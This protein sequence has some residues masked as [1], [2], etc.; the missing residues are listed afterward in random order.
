MM[1]N[2]ILRKQSWV[3]SISKR[4]LTITPLVFSI[5]TIRILLASM[6]IILVF[7][8]RIAYEESKDIHGES[9]IWEKDS[10]LILPNDIERFRM[11]PR[12]LVDY[13][14]RRA[15]NLLHFAWPNANPDVR[16]L[17]VEN[18]RSENGIDWADTSHVP[19]VTFYYDEE[20]E[21]SVDCNEL[22]IQE[23]AKKLKKRGK[24]KQY[25]SNKRFVEN[26]AKYN[27]INVFQRCYNYTEREDSTRRSESEVAFSFREMRKLKRNA[28]VMLTIVG[29][30]IETHEFKPDTSR[31][32]DSLGIK[33]I[34]DWLSS[35]HKGIPSNWMLAHAKYFNKNHES[36]LIEQK[37]AR[38]M[39]FLM[40]FAGFLFFAF[41]FVR[42]GS[43]AIIQHELKKREIV[44]TLNTPESLLL[45][46]VMHLWFLP[47]NT[48][49]SRVKI[50][51]VCN[52]I[53]EIQTNNAIKEEA[54]Q[55]GVILAKYHDPGGSR[56]L[57]YKELII[58]L[59]VAT[60]KTKKRKATSVERQFA[61]MELIDGLEIL[62]EIHARVKVAI[63]ETVPIA[64]IEYRQEDK[65]KKI[66]RQESALELVKRR[67]PDGHKFKQFSLWQAGE[68]EKLALVLLTLPEIH[69]KAIETFLSHNNID[70]LLS[71]RSNF[72]E[73]LNNRDKNW[74]IEAL[75]LQV[76]IMQETKINLDSY[77]S[78]L[79]NINVIL[80][81]GGKFQ[82]KRNQLG[83]SLGR[84]GLESKPLVFDPFEDFKELSK[85]IKTAAD[86]TLYLLYSR[87]TNHTTTGLLEK[88]RRNYIAFK[89]ISEHEFLKEVVSWYKIVTQELNY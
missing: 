88:N 40:Y 39:D 60:G 23:I 14:R 41:L 17:P 4:F 28:G 11:D 12:K 52:E 24:L 57:L 46:R 25:H 48:V 13:N 53:R 36:Y 5:W 70:G 21:K 74:I 59:K 75:K 51:S 79:N 62:S 61:L 71:K 45:L 43:L 54:N 31:G 73:A 29:L 9:R 33:K 8:S 15:H 66:S 86:R 1:P 30:V 47:I 89:S 63:Q 37:T 64:D 68:L 22:F 7:K 32:I 38:R 72:M 78:L 2:N 19:I 84:L 80:I 85:N 27:L 77:S 20:G 55:L 81:G 83:N 6:L 69:P 16:F 26:S 35:E 34:L 76:P 65:T 44:L 87:A 56:F 10:R 18:K 82:P 49:K 42:P 3:K 67:L 58:K 50:E